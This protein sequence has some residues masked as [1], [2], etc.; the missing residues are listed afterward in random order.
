MIDINTSLFCVLGDPIEH[1]LSPAMHN[2][3]FAETGFNGVYLA[4]RVKDIASAMKGIRG[5]GVQGASVTIPH[6]TAVM[7]FLDSIDGTARRIGAVNTIVNRNGVLTGYNTDCLGAVNALEAKTTLRDKEV[8]IIGAGGAARAVG[9]GVVD[10]GG[11]VTV[12]NRNVERGRRLAAEL[13]GK[14]NPLNRDGILDCEILV[15]TTS[16]GMAPHSDAMP[17]SG[18]RLKK[19]MLI[20]D[21]VYNP[22]KT[23]LLQTANAKGCTAIGGVSM[24]VN[25]G[26][27]QFELWTGQPAPVGVMRQIVLELL[28][29]Q[30]MHQKK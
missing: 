25:Q 1:S 30:T 20:M 23:K 26:A 7:E 14:F 19:E 4:F 6:K 13:N 15:N 22:L 29:K 17:I 16:V 24:F 18:T 5:L 21:I 10:A 9:F 27:L 3:A 28:S 2:R 11:R 12:L 8:T